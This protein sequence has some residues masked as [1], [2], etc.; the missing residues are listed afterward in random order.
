[1]WGVMQKERTMFKK[2]SEGFVFGLGFG[3]SFILIWYI[4]AFFLFPKLVGSQ[5][6]K[7]ISKIESRVDH[8]VPDSADSIAKQYRQFDELSLN[9]Q[10]KRSSVIAIAKYEKSPD[11][12]LK[13]IIKEFLKKEPRTIIHYNIGDEY[14]SLSVYPEENTRYGDGV[15]IFFV[16][17]PATMKSA[18]TYTGGRIHSFGDMPIE[19][20]RAKCKEEN[21]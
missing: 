13:A 10:I 15:V 3:I 11:G 21:A 5:L 12:K 20:L 7:T 6:E 1:M 17:S 8:H 16:G 18:V 14:P 4:S 19:L 2:F 9:E